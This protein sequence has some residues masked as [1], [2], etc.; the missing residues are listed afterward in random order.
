MASE[1][2]MYPGDEFIGD[3]EADIGRPMTSDRD[4]LAGII[5]RAGLY[6]SPEAEAVAL[7]RLIEA[8]VRPPARVIATAAK[9][10]ALPVGTI[11]LHA[12]CPDSNP[13][14]WL[15][16]R[17]KHWRISPGL[18]WEVCGDKATHYDSEDLECH[19]DHGGPLTVI[20]IPTEETAR[21]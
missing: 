5:H 7:D 3:P 14:I 19:A 10:D 6:S 8:G 11:L 17:G 16:V 13:C 9:A 1:P 2:Q 20:Y 21:G 15:R 18:Y 12:E 4:T